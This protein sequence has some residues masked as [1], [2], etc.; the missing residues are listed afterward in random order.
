MFHCLQPK[1]EKMVTESYI[2]YSCSGFPH[3]RFFITMISMIILFALFYA[4]KMARICSIMPDFHLLGSAPC[5]RFPVDELG[6][7]TRHPF[8]FQDT[9]HGNSY[10]FMLF[11]PVKYLGRGLMT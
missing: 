4:M 11:V 6:E 5:L 7:R 2:L 9:R 1:S 8:K 3:T 10:T